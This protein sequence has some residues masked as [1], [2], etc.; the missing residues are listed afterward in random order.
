MEKYRILLVDDD[1]YVLEYFEEVFEDND[2]FEVKCYIDSQ[3]AYEEA[4]LKEQF[5]FIYLDIYMPKL[6]GI[7]LCKKTRKTSLNK[8]AYIYAYTSE[9]RQKV[10]EL[11]FE[12]GM[13]DVINKM[14]EYTYL[15]QK[16]KAEISREKRKRVLEGISILTEKNG[17]FLLNDMS[18]DLTKTEFIILK[19]LFINKGKFVN[20]DD[21]LKVMSL[22]SYNKIS[23][24]TIRVHLDNI[25]KKFFVIEPTTEYI[26]NHHNKGYM[27]RHC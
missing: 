13:D 20:Y 22:Y 16:M 23:Y 10:Q 7:E 6:D 25:R 15:I 17:N 18:L 26:L 11:F 19:A 12:A 4:I 24:S 3:K 14:L 27:L 21:I 5:H 9:I 1:P 2:E 8:D